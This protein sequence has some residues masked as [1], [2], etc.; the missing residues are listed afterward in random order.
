[1]AYTLTLIKPDCLITTV[2][3]TE[4]T[5]K[6]WICDT[7]AQGNRRRIASVEA[8]T[9]FE[10]KKRSAKWVLRAFGKTRFLEDGI[11]GES[12]TEL[13]ESPGLYALQWGSEDPINLFVKQP[14]H[15]DKCYCKWRIAQTFDRTI[16][17]SPQNVIAVDNP[18]VS[19]QHATIS[20][21][22]GC[23][24]IIDKGSANG[25]YVNSR[26]LE[27][28]AETPLKAG[29]TVFILGLQLIIG[30][31]F[32][33]HN[34]P[35]HTVSVA[36]C[37]ALVK[38]GPYRQDAREQSHDKAV[39]FDDDL[40]PAEQ[41]FFRSPRIKRDIDDRSWNI[42]APPAQA[43]LEE[44]PAILK[45]GP[46]LGMALASALMGSLMVLNMTQNSNG[47]DLNLVR[48]IPMA[49]MVL[50]MILGA[51][52][53]PNLQS[54]YNKKQNAKKEE[55]RQQ[56]YGDYL[57][58]CMHELEGACAEQKNILVAN[59]IGIAECQRRAEVKDRRL[60][61]RTALHSDFLE[62]RIGIG[63]AVAAMDVKWP[64]EKLA[65][66]EDSLR[67]QVLELARKPLMLNNLPLS[68]PLLGTHVCG[69]ITESPLE[70][71][72]A[73]QKRNEAWGFLRGLIGQIAVLHAP[74]EVKL[75]L[76]ANEEE[77]DQ[78]GL[79]GSLPHIFD[80]ERNMRFL[81]TSTRDSREI[82]LLLEREIKAR[83]TAQPPDVISDYG[84]YYVV[85]VT[86]RALAESVAVIARL[87]TLRTNLGFSLVVMGDHLREMPKEC[88]RII[89]LGVSRNDEG[90]LL[91]KSYDP[92]DAAG[93]L[94]LFEPDI[95]LDTTQAKELVLNLGAV[96]Y[97]G[98]GGLVSANT[99]PKSLGFLEM[100]EVGKPEHL[101]IAT[102][103]ADSNPCDSLE[104]PLGVSE[105]GDLSMLDIHED[106]HGPHGLIAG[107]TG[108]GKSELIITYILSL[109]VNY[110]PDEVSFVLIDYKGGGL[111][112][113]FEGEKSRLPHLA[114]TITNLDGP[115]ITRAMIAIDSELRRRQSAFNIARD[116]S[117]LGS[118]DIYKYQELHRLGQVPEPIPHMLIISDEFAELKTQEP[119]FMDE[120]IKTA[121]IGRS[122]GVHLI[123]ATQKPSGVVNDQIWSNAKFKVCLKVADAQ[124]SREVIKCE[125][126]ATLVDPG[127]F[128]LQVGYNELFTLGQSAYAGTKYRPKEYFEKPKDNAVVL[129]SN[130]GRPLL[131]IRPKP[132]SGHEG[133]APDASAQSSPEQVAVLQH[134]ASVAQDEMLQAPALW[135]DPIPTHIYLDEIARKYPSPAHKGAALEPL[136]GE[137][138]D[139][140]NQNQRPLYL[141]I[142]ANGNTI[143]YGSTGS[144]KASLVSTL[145]Y[146]LYTHHDALSLNAYLIDM[147][148]ETLMS[149][150]GAPQTGDVL[151]GVDAEKIGKLFKMLKDILQSRR[152][153]LAVTGRGF[154]D[155]ADA[156]LEARRSQG[157][158][159]TALRGTSRMAAPLEPMPSVL[160]AIND[161]DV[162]S[163][164]YEEH[165]ND[166][167]ML[168][169]DGLRYG[170]YFLLTASRANSV[171]YRLLPNFNQK[172]VLKFNNDDDYTNVF[173]S[174]R[175]VV[176]P[177]GYMRG[178]MKTDKPYEFQAARISSDKSE[179]EAVRELC[180]LLQ[181]NKAQAGYTAKPV[182]CLP[183]VVT[184]NT[185]RDM[186]DLVKVGLDKVPLGI[187]REDIGLAAHDFIRHKVLLAVGE[188]E[189][190]QVGFIEA[191]LA[192]LA[193]TAGL[194]VSVYDIDNLLP[195]RLADALKG[196]GVSVHRSAA[197]INDDLRALLDVGQDEPGT[198]IAESLQ[199]FVLEDPGASAEGSL[200][201]RLPDPAV[202]GILAD[203]MSATDAE[204]PDPSAEGSLS[205][206]SSAPVVEDRLGSRMVVIPSLRG[207][208]DG[209]DKGL[210]LLFG[211]FVTE[212]TYKRLAGMIV[213]GEPAR[214]SSFSYESWF[215]ELVA[216]GNGIW[217]GPGFDSQQLLKSS[218]SA[219]HRSPLEKD[220]AWLVVKGNARAIKHIAPFEESPQ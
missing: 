172:L 164:L 153:T 210:L 186:F 205:D 43:K 214:F 202:E 52:L 150:A 86:S 80:N 19:S 104:A 96:N 4:I 61:E 37:P 129:V 97:G 26:A 142:T 134:I 67:E 77:R 131:S 22:E 50:V 21:R 107:T 33:S 70:Q 149:F 83:Q 46:S 155:Y 10:G 196:T 76:F 207:F 110:R 216:S 126:A 91:S 18:L 143:I 59:R 95:S 178:L 81:A 54:R 194:C 147:G 168:T 146:S 92:R 29:D 102:R 36:P 47:S 220:M 141:P 89:E 188:D 64:E 176:K 212:G 183:P 119:E 175:N 1:M 135:L 45:L 162:F 191:G 63:D 20:Y 152:R 195:F 174:M 121:R 49:A 75:V 82:S 165:M 125:D 170:I 65:M 204:S 34:N 66:E 109:A 71:S 193:K 40:A 28:G 7:D 68:L 137:L 156:A 177:N 16:G 139:P 9:A 158:S 118:M 197:A 113:A 72:E 48:V 145:L 199:P 3:P 41:T 44:P 23:F 122:L 84:A 211:Q 12:T 208:V 213:C 32:I 56:V 88:R 171:N 140:Y 180:K 128:Y 166:V 79:F 130:T 182:P 5:G 55:K 198:P 2:L 120:L 163:E 169:R 148:A 218:Y 108:S 13:C 200:S 31:D 27:K 6:H 35:G 167:T 173:G 62:L 25:T 217:F 103:W 98:S 106:F 190:L 14:Q 69:I 15:E 58:K 38:S 206:C 74:D 157:A 127:R 99:L 132:D 187:T 123:L 8:E 53:W 179:S 124:D 219:D 136:I 138:D 114:G 215:R 57:S 73:A 203:C 87:A 51:V 94:Q 112:G 17:R 30:T 85:V 181:S 201:D 105:S 161:F 151:L 60:Y 116:V 115:A 189:T 78:W 133:P 192:A 39:A 24:F 154:S 160:V 117:G 93:A 184:L 101:N 209:I 144:G 159:A 11:T 100:F 111:A 90:K 185:F 42:E